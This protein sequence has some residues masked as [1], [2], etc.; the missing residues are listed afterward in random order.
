MRNESSKIIS[1]NNMDLIK[2]DSRK[3]L[4]ADLETKTGMKINRINIKEF[5]L[6]KN[7]VQIEVFYFDKLN[8]H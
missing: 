6:A 1:Y 4:I 5:D 7:R 3:E 8:K 2:P